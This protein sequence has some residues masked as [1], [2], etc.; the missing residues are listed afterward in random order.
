PLIEHFYHGASPPRRGP[1]GGGPV[2]QILLCVLPEPGATVGGAWGHPGQTWRRAHGTSGAATSAALAACVQHTLHTAHFHAPAVL[3]RSMTNL[4]ALTPAL[5]K[6]RVSLG[7]LANASWPPCRPART[8][9]PYPGVIPS[10]V[11]SAASQPS[12]LPD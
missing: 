1:S 6:R 12:R 11:G 9:I 10:S 4:A 5:G 3:H 2:S 7:P 8:T